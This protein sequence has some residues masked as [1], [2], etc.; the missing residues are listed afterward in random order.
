M[1]FETTALHPLFAAEVGGIDVSQPTEAPIFNAVLAA[2]AE[3]AVLVFH[4]PCLDEDRQV[5]FASRFGPLEA[6]NGVLTTGVKQRVTPQLVDISN[7]D[8]TNGLLGRQDRRRMFSLGNQLWHTDSSFKRTPA[9][10]S[11]LH[12][13][14]VVPEGGETQFVDTRAAWDALPEKV[15]AKAEGLIVEHSIFTSREKLGFTDFSDEERAATPPVHRRLVRDHAESGRKALYL[16]SHA[17][18]VVGWPVPEGRMF[19]HELMEH[20]TQP[21]FVYT[22]HW[23]VGDVVIWDNRCTMH[24]VRPFDA[25]AYARDMRRATIQDTDPAQQDLRVA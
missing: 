14:T 22:H 7:L 16:A 11:L 15:K 17:S 10:Y 3:H 8:E 9:K 2:L 12:A 25:D 1:T 21:Q 23:Q 13:H 4:G 5:A 19:L 24:R 6:Q 18:H 20:A